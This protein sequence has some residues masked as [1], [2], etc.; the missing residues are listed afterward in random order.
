MFEVPRSKGINNLPDELWVC[1]EVYSKLNIPRN[2]LNQ[3]TQTT[4]PDTSLGK[5]KPLINKVEVYFQ[6]AMEKLKVEDLVFVV[7]QRE[8]TFC[9]KRLEGIQSS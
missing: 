2:P 7:N 3:I 5:I 9:K 1:L 8:V 4:S 6:L